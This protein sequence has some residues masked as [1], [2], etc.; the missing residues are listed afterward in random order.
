MIYGCGLGR[1]RRTHG[2]AT[3]V[4]LA[5]QP[6]THVARQP[7]VNTRG[8]PPFAKFPLSLDSFMSLKLSVLA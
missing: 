3:F 2:K 6:L 4:Q 5:R 7:D 1:G 8:I